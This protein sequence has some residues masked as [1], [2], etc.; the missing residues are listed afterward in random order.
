MQH[1]NSLGRLRTDSLS[2]IVV[3]NWFFSLK[4]TRKSKQKNDRTS[5]SAWDL[6]TLT[7]AV[8]RLVGNIIFI[9]S[10]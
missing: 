2:S 7:G 4:R 5:R 8:K 10:N 6:A 1:Y 9:I 3:P